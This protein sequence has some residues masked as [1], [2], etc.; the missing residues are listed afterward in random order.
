MNQIKLTF[1]T[2]IQ[3]ALILNSDFIS[4]LPQSKL[5]DDLRIPKEP[6]AIHRITGGFAKTLRRNLRPNF[7]TFKKVEA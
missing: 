7:H 6:S 1:G 3:F 2:F 4:I 5:V